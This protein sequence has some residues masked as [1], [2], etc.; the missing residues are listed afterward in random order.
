M[1][2]RRGAATER[3]KAAVA[4][5]QTFGSAGLPDPLRTLAECRCNV[6]NGWIVLK[7]SPA[8][9]LSAI[10]EC[11]WRARRLFIALL[12]SST[13]QSIA[14]CCP[15]D[16]F[17]N[18]GGKRTFTLPNHGSTPDPEETIRPRPRDDRGEPSFEPSWP[19]ALHRASSV[20]DDPIPRRRPP[21][22]PD[23]LRSSDV[24]RNPRCAH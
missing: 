14:V 18:I 9:L 12:D 8:W 10:F 20:V 19:C 17:N 11:G 22:L 1:R 5:N 3:A 24:T 15:S 23:Q 13:S 21:N 16:F 6:S 2:Q 4:G 7:N